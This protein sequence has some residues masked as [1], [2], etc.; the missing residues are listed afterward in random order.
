MGNKGDFLTGFLVGGLV[1]VAAG[2]LLAPAPG[3]ESLRTLKERAAEATLQARESAGEITSKLRDG[4][5][6]IAYRIKGRL[7]SSEEVEK[8]LEFAESKLEELEEQ[9]EPTP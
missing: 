8:A 6:D 2:L 1:G 7:P 9:L 5:Q 4:A 3:E